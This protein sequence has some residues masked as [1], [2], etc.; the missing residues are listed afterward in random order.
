MEPGRPRRCLPFIEVI[1]DREVQAKPFRSLL[2]RI[3]P[4]L[5]HLTDCLADGGNLEATRDVSKFWEP[6]LLKGL[7]C[8]TMTWSTSVF[9]TRFA[10]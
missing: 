8:A 7:Q 2:E 1:C 4:T 10:L 3:R 6:A 9:T 5:K